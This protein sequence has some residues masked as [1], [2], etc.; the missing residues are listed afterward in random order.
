MNPST[1]EPTVLCFSG[2]DP[3]GGAGIQADIEALISMRCYPCTII[4]GLT[5]QDTINIKAL[6]PQTPEHFTQQARLILQD[7]NISA[8]KI[9]LIGH[10]GIAEAIY[11]ILTDHP[12]IPVIFDPV[13]AA[14][15]GKRLSN[16]SLLATIKKKLL[17]R[18][19]IL[20][21]N[22]E[23]A[24]LLSETSTSLDKCGQSLLEQGCKAVL[25]TGGHEA[26]PFIIN[27]FYQPE[28]PVELFE[29]ERLPYTY[30]GSG[31]TLA[32]SLAGLIAKQI[33]PVTA[34][35]EAQQY[36]WNTLKKARPIGKGQLI[37]N[38][39]YWNQ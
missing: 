38:R 30:H 7:L 10:S 1:L 13:L 28:K 21:P 17:P 39:F 26:E 15:G 14:G 19:T 12:D 29:W 32:A 11:A 2:H 25:I 34:A 22:S 27:R 8:I 36:T 16:V 6:L 37:P 33:D 23:E 5:V 20:T 18:T 31:C 4:T 24:R 9:G 3:S 35:F